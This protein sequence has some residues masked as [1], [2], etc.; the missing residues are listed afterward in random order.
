MRKL[1]LCLS[2]VML[3]P[4][5]AQEPGD[6]LAKIPALAEQ[7]SGEEA[8]RL[9]YDVLSRS[10]NERYLTAHFDYLKLIMTQDEVEEYHQADNKAA[11]MHQ[12][13]KKLDPT[14]QTITNERISEHFKRYAYAMTRYADGSRIDGR[15][16]LYIR[17]GQPLRVMEVPA[18]G[19][20]LSSQTWIYSFYGENVLLNLVYQGDWRI[21][22][23]VRDFVRGRAEPSETEAHAILEPRAGLDKSYRHALG[24]L[25]E[26]RARDALSTKHPT[27][28]DGPVSLV[29]NGLDEQSAGSGIPFTTFCPEVNAGSLNSVFA[30][31]VFP[32]GNLHRLEC[33]FGVPSMRDGDDLLANCSL[34]S[35]TGIEI[36]RLE[37]AFG[38]L[39][40]Q[41]AGRTWQLDQLLRPGRYRLV[42]RISE[43]ITG[44]KDEHELF[45]SIADPVDKLCVSDVLFARSAAPVKDGDPEV[46]RKGSITV[47][48]EPAKTIAADGSALLYFEISNLERDKNG[49]TA[50]EVTYTLHSETS[51]FLKHVSPFMKKKPHITEK[52]RRVKAAALVQ[53]IVFIN[54]QK[55]NPGRFR[56]T[57]R[58]RDLVGRQTAEKTLRFEVK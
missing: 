25:L 54:A 5:F 53:D 36:A 4:L 9:L 32:E 29:L 41:S 7:G 34:F 22:E 35:S 55:L 39:D 38:S 49:N 44:K 58:V 47:F 42:M 21:A 20:V 56:A 15:G 52:F 57:V 30:T 6:Q 51:G 19:R 46:F 13:W 10:K 18:S 26:G 17:Y 33:Y 23:L 24:E 14:P 43:S 16:M 40:F 1:I 31:A 45:L 28:T 11:F 37:A 50:Y 8:T 48:P 27:R 3:S 2:L 12:L